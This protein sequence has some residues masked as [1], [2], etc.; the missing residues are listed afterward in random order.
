[1]VVAFLLIPLRAL[2]LPAVDVLNMPPRLNLAADLEYLED[3]ERE[4]TLSDVQGRFADRFTPGNGQTLNKGYTNSA[5]WLHVRLSNSAKSLATIRRAVLQLDYPMLDDIEIYVVRQEV[6]EGYWHS[7]DLFPASSRPIEHGTFVFPVEMGPN[8][9]KDIYL[10]VKGSSSMRLPLILWDELE[11]HKAERTSALLHGLFYGILMLMAFYNLCL[12]ISVRDINYLLYVGYTCSITLFQSIMIGDAPVY[13]WGEFPAINEHIMPVSIALTAAFLIYFSYRVLDFSQHSPRIGIFLKYLGGFQILLLAAALTLPYGPSIRTASVDALL[14]CLCIIVVAVYA[15]IQRERSAIYFLFAWLMLLTGAIVLALVSLGMMPAN[16]FTTNAFYFG[17]TIEV[18]LL[19]LS[20][21]ERMRFSLQARV[22]A[23]QRVNEALTNVNAALKESNTLKDEF[24]ATISHELRTPMNGVIG[25][26]DQL[27]Q[28][29][30]EENQHRLISTADQSAHHLMSL[31]DSVLTY[32]ELASGKLLLEKQVISI[33]RLLEGLE[34]VFQPLCK[35]KA[36]TLTIE[37]E[38]G[39][40]LLSGDERR[41]EQMLAILLDNAVKFTARGGVELL[42]RRLPSENNNQEKILFSVIDSG[43]GITEAA[44]RH[45]FEKFRQ[46]NGAFSRGHGGLGI[47]LAIVKEL[48]LAMK[49][50]VDFDSVENEGSVFNL[51]VTLDHAP[52]NFVSSPVPEIT[53]TIAQPTVMIVEDNPTNQLVLKGILKNLGISVLTAN[54]GEEALALMQSEPMDAILMDCQMPVMDGFAATVAIRQLPHP[55]C[56]TPI[57]AVTAN[58]MAQDKAR[59]LDVGMNDYL[60][61]PVNTA[62][63]K[64]KLAYWL[65]RA[66]HPKQLAA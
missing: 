33:N 22:D 46:A 44:S 21:A 29:G 49:A 20:L 48:A 32:T 17:N 62:L 23:E 31:L 10:C 54:N 43:I 7:G 45:I 3:P 42:V 34:S 59:C 66:P 36:L 25:S 35:Q 52:E 8:T 51:R 26:I 6:A 55:L 28:P 30:D 41:L 47:G 63:L 58:A 40:P 18:T 19:S 9:I 13:L 37:C 53:F 61:K 16:A 27:K 5:Y 65:A 50:E 60:S 56:N 14:V 64:E 38:Q 39:L 57:I 11:F 2:A 15:A 12:F 1:M 4:F 24:L